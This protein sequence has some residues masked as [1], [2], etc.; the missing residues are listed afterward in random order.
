MKDVS[1]QDIATSAHAKP[2]FSWILGSLLHFISSL[3]CALAMRP[4]TNTAVGVFV[5]VRGGEE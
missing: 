1:Y 3:P 5:G 4:N 2:P